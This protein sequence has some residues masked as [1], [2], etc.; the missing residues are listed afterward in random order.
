MVG[1]P[2]PDQDDALS[3]PVVKNSPEVEAMRMVVNELRIFRAQFLQS[4]LPKGQT[5]QQPPL[6]LPPRTAVTKALK[7]AERDR[8][9]AKHEALVARLMPW[10]GRV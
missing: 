8:K 3:I 4:K 2:K 7:A 6:L 5:A 9:K 1:Q 10:K